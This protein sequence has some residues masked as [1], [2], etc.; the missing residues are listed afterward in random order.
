MWR[1]VRRCPRTCADVAGLPLQDWNSAIQ[2]P[3]HS[4]PG[5]RVTWA[6]PRG[7]RRG[8]GG[9]GGMIEKDQNAMRGMVRRCPRT[10]ADV[11]GLSS[12]SIGIAQVRSWRAPHPGPRVTWVGP[13]GVR[14]RPEDLF[15][16]SVATG[17]HHCHGSVP[18][19]RVAWEGPWRDR[20]PWHRSQGLESPGRDRGGIL[21]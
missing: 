6:G 17:E 13:C 16:T 4:R 15:C 11:A 3:A 9:L 19:P 20:L 10:C 14:R 12:R 2:V 21:L 1:M 7:V 18:G 8:L 5:P